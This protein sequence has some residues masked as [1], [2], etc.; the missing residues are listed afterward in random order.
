MFARWEHPLPTA[1]SSA[2][3]LVN[4]RGT[5]GRSDLSGNTRSK[6]RR[7]HK[8]H[9]IRQVRGQELIEKSW[10]TCQ[11]AVRRYGRKGFMPPSEYPSRLAESLQSCPESLQVFGV[12]KG[13]LL[14]GFSENHIQGDAVLFEN[15][16]LDPEG[17][18]DYSSY[19]L[20]D[21]MLD[22][23]LNQMGLG[24]VSDGTRRL[25]HETGIHEFLIEKFGF[26]REPAQLHVVYRPYFSALVHGAFPF[27]GLIR[28]ARNFLKLDVFEKGE[29][30][31]LQE[32]IRRTSLY[33]T[34]AL[35]KR[36]HEGWRNK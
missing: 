28:R 24:Y 23:Y 21:S 7:G 12:F 11:A 34:A 4:R 32:S 35:E 31:M 5:Y 17:L 26:Q 16:W 25:H 14:L 20:F 18:R 9:H 3:W 33:N 13:D 1:E 2:W 30:I 19:A 27:R 15:I 22:H 36:G 6:V 29:G 8:R 10:R